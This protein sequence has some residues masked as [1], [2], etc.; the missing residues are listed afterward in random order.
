MKRALSRKNLWEAM[1]RSL[2]SAAGV[3]ASGVPSGWL[4]GRRYRTVSRF[5]RDAQWW[6]RECASEYQAERIRGICALAYERTEYYREVFSKAG[7]RPENL[8]SPEDLQRL[9]T[10]DKAVLRK[11]LERMC[12][13]SPKHRS[14]D[15]ISTGGSSGAP[16]WF[17]IGRERS[18]IEYA[19][20][21]A[22]WRRAGYELGMPM[23]VL[24]GRL[25]QPDR[26]GLR[27]E[28]D[29]VLRHHYYSNF[30]TSDRA[31]AGYVAHMATVGPC[32]LH[33][34]PSSA[35]AIVRFC[36]RGGTKPPGNIHGV[37]LESENVHADQ[38]QAVGEMFGCRVFSSYGH[39]EK[40]VLAAECEHSTDYHVWPTYGYFELLDEEGKPVTTPGKRGEIVG[41][42]FTNTVMPFIRYRTGDYATYVGERCEACGREHTIIRDVEGRWPSGDLV[43]V[44]GSLISMTAM[45]VHDD[46]FVSVR[47]FQFYQDTAGRAVLRVVP[48]DGF[49]E[50]ERRKI[51]RNLG[52]KLDGRLTFDIELVDSIGLTPRGKAIYVDQRIG[53]ARGGPSFDR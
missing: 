42:G 5:L 14:V 3:L 51:L 27:Q 20:L 29:P 24:R 11:N 17:Y 49:D 28:Y 47:Q 36:R 4:L 21:T 30:H 12:A 22:S 7:L 26:S 50:T 34:Y 31:L 2:K 52:R 25:V 41:T 33:A 46:T 35:M 23:V 40:L 10:I 15:Y 53:A 45:N 1:P 19:Y 38:R 48:A 18:A 32:F 39:S 44:D 8:R 9:P 37:I 16:L 13:R 43:A 6:P